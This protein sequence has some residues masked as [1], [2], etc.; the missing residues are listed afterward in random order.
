MEKRKSSKQKQDLNNALREIET[1][2]EKYKIE[3]CLVVLTNSEASCGA[4]SGSPKSLACA[5]VKGME[6]KF[7][8]QEELTLMVKLL[9]VII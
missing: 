9:N 3:N 6:C 5:I 7:N 2:L 1:I 8:G 4:I